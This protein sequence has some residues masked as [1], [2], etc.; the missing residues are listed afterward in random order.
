MEVNEKKLLIKILNAL[1]PVGSIYMSVNSTSPAT[2]FGGT[3][4]RITGRFLL[5]ATDGGANGGNS[6]ASIKP[7]YTGGE[8]AHTLSVA[9]MPS[10]THNYGNWTNASPSGP[11]VG[12]LWIGAGSVSATSG[13]TYTGGSGSHNNMPPYLA[14]YVWKRTK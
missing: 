2:F 5:A 14:V 13:I 6:N 7:G 11:D 4:E 1:Y 9:E 3:W 12:V 8:A 10:H